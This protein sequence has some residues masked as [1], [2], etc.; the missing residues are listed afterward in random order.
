MI[1][2][3]CS[4]RPYTE[5]FT[6]MSHTVTKTTL[7][8]RHRDYYPNLQMRKLECAQLGRDR[9]RARKQTQLGCL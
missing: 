8:N 4:A 9:A 5:Y 2:H 3:Q 6:Y 7:I 1:N